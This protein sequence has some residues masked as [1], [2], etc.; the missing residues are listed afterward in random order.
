MLGTGFQVWDAPS[1]ACGC[2]VLGWLVLCVGCPWGHISVLGDGFWLW[3]A[4]GE[5]PV[6]TGCWAAPLGK[7]SPAAGTVLLF[8]GELRDT[9]WAAKHSV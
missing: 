5:V 9:L 2:C 8:W 7:P 6:S 4:S 3:D 1:S